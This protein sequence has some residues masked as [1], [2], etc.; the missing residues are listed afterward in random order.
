[1][2]RDGWDEDRE[3]TLVR[4]ASA[5]DLS[6]YDLLVRRYRP[7]AV[8]V[9][10]QVLRNREQAEDAAQDALLAAFAALPHLEEVRRFPAWLSTIVRHRAL[11]ISQGERR[12][13]VPIDRVILSYTPA[14]SESLAADGERRKV[15]EA[16]EQLSAELRPVV[17]LY[18]LDDWTVR[19][20]SSFMGL[21]E[22]TVKWRLHTSRKQLRGLLS[23][24]EEEKHERELV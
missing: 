22:T 16:I 15:L 12:A 1:M 24:E 21:P 9:A 20:I 10:G 5:G 18:Y 11:R 2:E 13:S 4:A 23:T 14:L 6:A 8:A 19:E 3:A 17:E 7:A